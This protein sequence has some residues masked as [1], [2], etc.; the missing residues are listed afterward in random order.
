[1]D[2][3]KRQKLMVLMQRHGIV[4]LDYSDDTETIS[5]SFA[6]D[7]RPAIRSTGIGVF[8]KHHPMS[9]NS[10]QINGRIKKGICWDF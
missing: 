8:F 10:Q 2:T 9:K 6:S 5:L 3:D 1:M 7:D 4:E